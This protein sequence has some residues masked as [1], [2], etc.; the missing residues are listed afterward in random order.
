MQ[1]ATSWGLTPSW[2]GQVH[3]CERAHVLKRH[4]RHLSG[5]CV[6][7]QFDRVTCY[8]PAAPGWAGMVLLTPAIDWFVVL[9]SILMDRLALSLCLVTVLGLA[10]W[11]SI[12]SLT[13]SVVLGWRIETLLP[14]NR[15]SRDHQPSKELTGSQHSTDRSDRSTKCH[16]KGVANRSLHFYRSDASPSP[17]HCYTVPSRSTPKGGIASCNGDIKDLRNLCYFSS[18]SSI[19]DNNAAII[20]GLPLISLTASNAFFNCSFLCWVRW[21]CS[22]SDIIIVICR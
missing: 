20:S 14:L 2:L 17:P 8:A 15:E 10:G 5:S 12:G 19:A 4:T 6:F 21:F 18:Y 9:L 16:T 13:S 7:H 3:T 1:P 11:Q 22:E